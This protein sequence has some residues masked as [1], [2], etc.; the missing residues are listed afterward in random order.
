MGFRFEPQT[1]PDVILVR[2]AHYRDTRGWFAETYRWSEFAQ[3]GIPDLFMQDNHSFSAAK[4]TLRGLHFQRPPSAQGK[5]VRCIAGSIYDVAI[6]LRAESLTYGQWVAVDLRPE[7][8][9]MLWIPIGFAH[10][11]QTL[12]PDTHVAYKTTAEY[13]AAA[14]SGIRWDDPFLA[15]PWPVE[16]PILSDRD[17]ALPLWLS[18]APHFSR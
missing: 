13:D 1:I 12:E 14:E 3:H 15:I 9:T 10:A 8:G 11:F 17:M 6:D 2:T 4:G 16:R 5:L 7:D 18:S